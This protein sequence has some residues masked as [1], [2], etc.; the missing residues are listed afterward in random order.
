[1]GHSEWILWYFLNVC[2]KIVLNVF[3]DFVYTAALAYI[4]LNY[5]AHFGNWKVYALCSPYLDENSLTCSW[6][7]LVERSWDISQNYPLTLPFYSN[8]DQVCPKLDCFK[9]SCFVFPLFFYRI[10]CSFIACNFFLS[11]PRWSDSI[12]SLCEGPVMFELL[13]E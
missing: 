2:I 12:R 7:G 5:T 3:A 8:F 6:W 4:Q 1:M 10:N 11:I 9:K 13:V